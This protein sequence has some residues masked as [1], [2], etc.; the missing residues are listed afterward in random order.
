MNKKNLENKRYYRRDSTTRRLLKYDAFG[1]DKQIPIGLGMQRKISQVPKLLTKRSAGYFSE[2]VMKEY[3][4]LTLI[5]KES[6][7]DST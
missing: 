5:R 1:D 7:K 4:N 3:K 6:R 2:A